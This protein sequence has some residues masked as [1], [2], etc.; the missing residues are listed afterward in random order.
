[1]RASVFS[2]AVFSASLLAACASGGAA[3]KTDVTP[4]APETPVESL[5][6]CGDR[7][8]DHDQILDPCDACPNEPENYN[9]IEDVDGCPETRLV[10]PYE[11]IA[12]LPS[13]EFESASLQPTPPGTRA[14][15]AVAMVLLEDPAID[16]AAVL[17]RAEATEPPSLGEAR[18]QAVLELLVRKGVDRERLEAHGVSAGISRRVEVRVLRRSGWDWFRWSGTEVVRGDPAPVGTRPSSPLACDRPPPRCR[19]Q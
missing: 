11:S 7:D 4:R 3:P 13:I 9:G 17:G 12:P 6:I 14:L 10:L 5:P 2:V 15:D 16:R 18:A 1:M 8:P 19:P